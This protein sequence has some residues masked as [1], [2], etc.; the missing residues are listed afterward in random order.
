SLKEGDLLENKSWNPRFTM[1]GCTIQNHRARSV[2][3]KSPLKTVIEDNYFSSMMSGVLLRGESKFWYESGAVEDLLIRG[4]TFHNAGDCG[5]IHAALYVTP[6][7]GAAFDSEECYDRNI[8]FE[9]NTIESF[10]P[11]I[12]I[13]DRVEGLVVSGNKITMND[14]HISPF[15]TAPLFE[16][17]NCES[18]KIVNNS[19]LGSPLEIEQELK[20]D[21]KSRRN[22]I[23]KG[24]TF[25][26]PKR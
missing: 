9:D 15:P 7:L 19:Y 17:I 6:L 14:E 18:A 3:L 11:R 13:A 23:F 12:V 10:N 22:L 24:N 26:T 2:V 21:V 4:N 8:R 1:R 5:S 16:L 25:D 20:A